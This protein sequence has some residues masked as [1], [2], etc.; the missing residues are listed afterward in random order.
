MTVADIIKDQLKDKVIQLDD[1]SKFGPIKAIDGCSDGILLKAG[2]D[3][4]VFRNGFISTECNEL[5]LCL[6]TK[7]KIV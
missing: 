2:S 6:F 1:G 7:F 5:S 3:L 4:C